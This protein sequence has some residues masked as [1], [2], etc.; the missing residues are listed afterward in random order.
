M[1]PGS[2]VGRS[3]GTAWYR[4]SLRSARTWP[5]C[6]RTW[7]RCGAPQP[8]RRR[9]RV[10]VW[11]RSVPLPCASLTGRC[12][13]NRAITPC[14]GGSARSR[15]IL[16][17][18]AAT[19]MWD[20]PTGSWR[21]RSATTFG[22][23]CRSF[24]RS[25]PIRRCTTAPTPATRAGVPCNCSAGRADVPAPRLRTCLLAAAHWRAAHEGLDGQLID[26]RFGGSRPAWEL[27]EELLTRVGPALVSDSG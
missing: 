4:W 10:R 2:R 17:S 19:C 9:M 11:L 6:G 18:V 14:R 16:R 15:T 13:T 23:G 21:C 1:R 7:W 25:P 12:R 5:S 26:L 24:R 8:T 20:C 22:R 3:S 27:V